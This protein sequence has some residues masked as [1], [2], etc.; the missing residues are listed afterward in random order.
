MRRS[1]TIAIPHACL[2]AVFLLALAA[3]LPAGALADERFV[4]HWEGEIQ[5]PGQALAVK[6]DLALDGG[7]WSG[8]IDIPAQGAKGLALG[9]LEVAGDR[10]TFSIAGVPGD[11]KFTG[12]LAGGEIAGDFTQGPATIPFRL[13]REVAP[14]PPRPQE[15]KPPYPYLVEEVT[16]RNGEVTLA[17]TLTLPVGDG[18]FVAAVLVTGSGAQNRDEELLGHKPFL[19]LADHLTRQGIAVLRSDDRGVGGSSGSV[20]EA[21]S[22]DFADDALAAIERLRQD[23]RIDP[24]KIG[25]IG[26]S[27]GGLVGPL[28]ASRSSSV[29]FVVMLAGPGVSG[30]EIL[31]HQLAKI[32]SANGVG[33]EAVARQVEIQRELIAAVI[34]EQPRER[35]QEIGRR[36]VELQSGGQLTGEQL[37]QTVDQALAGLTTPWFRYFVAHDPRPVLARLE[38]PVLALN[39]ELDLQVDPAQNL[40]PIEQALAG[41]AGTVVRELAGLNHLFQHATA[42]SPGEYA[43]IEETFAPEALAAISDFILERFAQRAR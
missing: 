25:I 26:H 17:G 31:P 9:G 39:G 37:E 18:P 16:Y 19:V 6:V 11:P 23:S 35:L 3:S 4:G 20:S 15:P 10:V 1:S 2:R 34:A 30:A 38:V 42:G 40:P 36:L 21:T 43:Q 8:T 28:A 22:S 24:G 12:V 33:E 27:E 5:T 13:G 32:L 29:A 14:P 7:V 41:K